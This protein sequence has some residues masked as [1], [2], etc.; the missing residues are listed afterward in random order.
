MLG[1]PPKRPRKKLGVLSRLPG[2]HTSME[3][4]VALC[5]PVPSRAPFRQ[6]ERGIGIQRGIQVESVDFAGQIRGY[7]RVTLRQS[8]CSIDE[9]PGPCCCWPRT[10]AGWLFLPS[11]GS[12]KVNISYPRGNTVDRG[13]RR[14]RAY[15][16][17]PASQVPS[18]GSDSTLLK[19]REGSTAEG[20]AETKF[21][22]VCR[23]WL[24]GVAGPRATY[25]LSRGDGLAVGGLG[26]PRR[27]LKNG[28][29]GRLHRTRSAGWYYRG[30]RDSSPAPGA[31][32][33]KAGTSE[34][35]VVGWC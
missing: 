19:I 21:G 20:S 24:D 17:F 26:C 6:A 32:V 29:Q 12:A 14:N 2:W 4:R 7:K 30:R 35:L 15:I 1:L 31:A 13:L 18:R 9:V 34:K 5:Q 11:S 23:G 8:C 28:F 25:H 22:S 27:D 16:P 33:G 3:M 10:G